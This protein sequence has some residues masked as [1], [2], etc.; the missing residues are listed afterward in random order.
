MMSESGSKTY[1]RWEPERY[2]HEAQSPAA[3]LPE[4]D[5]VFFLL[6][7]VP[8]LDLGRFYAPYE[9]ETRGAPPFDPAMMVCLLLYAY[10][11]GVFSSRKMALACERNLAFMAIVG[12]ERPDF[13]TISDFRK[14]HLEAFKDVFVH[15]VRLA[16]EAGLVKLGNVSTDGT[17]I[18]GNASRHKAMS[19]GYMK[20]AV[21]RLRE[22]IETLVTAAYQQ[23]EAEDAALGSRRGDELPAELARREQRLATIEAAMRRLEA[24]AKAEAEAE[25][26]RRA[27]AEAE[28][29]Q[30]GKSRRG[31][32]PQPVSE[33][34]DDQAQSS[35][36]DPELHIMRTTNKGW[37]YCGNAQ[38]SVDATCQIIVACDVTN[39]SND[40]QQ[41]EPMAQATLSI[42]AHAG[43]ERP[44]DESGTAQAIPATL[45]NGYYSAAAVAALETLG[46]D[47]YIATERQRHQMPQTEAPET[48]ATVQERMAAK[49]R[50]P[51]GKALYARRKVI[52]EPVFGQIKEAR[53]FRRFLLRGLD[54]IRGEWGLICLTHNLLKIWRYGS[55][56][57]AASC[58]REITQWA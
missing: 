11:V 19:Y 25:R 52:V 46:F 24:Q 8:Q 2:R 30:T 56:Q 51:A 40:K 9:T 5:L 37:D 14:L 55:A 3:K 20:K 15:V 21:E 29:T 12:Q 58:R 4:G 44:T 18:Q 6:D 57:S 38:V 42:L 32:A 39:A 13:R 45:D 54:A 50:T 17:K 23:D 7:T 27:A 31:K 49:V 22:E 41:A 53:G 16:G 28:R 34:P 33:T 10:C 48:P 47:P 35:F 26:Q 1:R 36:T 43:I